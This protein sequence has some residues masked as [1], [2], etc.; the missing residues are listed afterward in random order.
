MKQIIVI[1]KFGTSE[2]GNHWMLLSRIS[3]ALKIK[4]KAF[5][6][7]AEPCS[8]EIGEEVDA[9]EFEGIDLKWER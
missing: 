1:E 4:T 9:S 3:G 8:M 2:K 6:S 7:L 5:V